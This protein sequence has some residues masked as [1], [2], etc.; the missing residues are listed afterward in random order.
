[1]SH[2]KEN[3]YDD[4]PPPTKASLLRWWKAFTAK[5]SSSSNNTNL[6]RSSSSASSAANHK[7]TRA[8][9]STAPGAV[10]GNPTPVTRPYQ[11]PGRGLAKGKSGEGRVFGVSPEQ[12]LKYAAVAISTVSADGKPYVYGYVPIVVAKCGMM[13]K[14]SATATEGIFRVSG[15]NKRINQLQE[16]FDQPPRYGK[17]LDWAGFTVHDAA[18]VLRR[19]LNMM[20]EPVIPANLY[21]DFVHVLQRRLPEEACIAEYQ[22]LISLLPPTSRYLLL[23]L[24]DFLSLFVRSSHLNLMTASNLAVVFQPGLV[25]TRREGTGEGALLGFPGFLDG[26]VPTNPTS[27]TVASGAGAQARQGAGEHGRGKEVLEFLIEQQSRFMIGLEPPTSSASAAAAATQAAASW[28]LTPRTSSNVAG[29]KANIQAQPSTPTPMSASTPMGGS[30]VVVGPRSSSKGHKDEGDDNFEPPSAEAQL[31]RRGSERS[32]ERR[33]LRK[34]ADGLNA[35]VKRS[36][37]LPGRESS[38]IDQH[39]HHHRHHQPQHL[40]LESNSGRGTGEQQDSPML[41]VGSVP[42][43]KSASGSSSQ[44]SPRPYKAPPLLSS[45]LPTQTPP[46]TSSPSANADSKPRGISARRTPTSQPNVAVPLPRKSSMTAAS[47]T[48][49]LNNSLPSATMVMPSVTSTLSST[50]VLVPPPLGP[51]VSRQSFETMYTAQSQ[52]SDSMDV[53]GPTAPA[54]AAALPRWISHHGDAET[55][56][57]EEGR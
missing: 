49:L 48:T 29:N 32:V 39:Q 38:L 50:T 44:G 51:A 17:D 21:V 12:S 46:G 33:R 54:A 13:L 30:N 1:M 14:E 35:K 7:L 31:Y 52:R 5:T 16:L 22:R 8:R 57:S 55:T 45:P 34:A 4:R 18:S 42:M 23:Y 37:T 2:G 41:M 36:K 15:S 25:S 20:P 40:T 9:A 56:G 47:T 26:K 43:R 3:V 6:H 19:Y 11:P 24:L 28:N 53:T 27:Q 10:S